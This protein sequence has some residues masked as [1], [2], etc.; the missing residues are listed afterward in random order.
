MKVVFLARSLG[1]G[2]AERQL[3]MLAKGLFERG[4]EVSVLVFYPGDPLESE[5]QDV[6]VPVTGLGKRGRWDV[7]GFLL[8]LVRVLRRERPNVL[9]SYLPMPNLLAVLNRPIVPGIRIVW[10]VRASF[11]DLD[12]YDL[13]SRLSYAIERRLSRLADLIV[14]NSRAGRN[15]AVAHGFPAE[16]TVVAFNG[17][18]I[19]C[20]QPNPQ[21][22]TMAQ[23]RGGGTGR[24]PLVANRWSVSLFCCGD[25]TRSRAPCRG[26]SCARCILSGSSSTRSKVPSA[27]VAGPPSSGAGDV[28]DRGSARPDSSAICLLPVRDDGE[29]INTCTLCSNWRATATATPLTF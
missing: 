27:L 6:G 1:F 24:D 13:V 3:V 11:M 22:G 21:A 9:H 26:S 23:C 10:G 28:A 8:Q 5:L 20:F 15:Y 18:D 7:V 12:R 25:A 17:I 19:T 29:A 14:A 16:R 4:H 2:E